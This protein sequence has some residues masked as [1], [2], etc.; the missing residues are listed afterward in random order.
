MSIESSRHD[1]EVTGVPS[2]H[3]QPLQREF[4]FEAENDAQLDHRL[5]N[6]DATCEPTAQPTEGNDILIK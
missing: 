2:L 6:A 4:E 3:L 1:D 5:R